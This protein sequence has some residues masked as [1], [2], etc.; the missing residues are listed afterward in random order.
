MRRML[1]GWWCGLLLVSAA[2]G[3]GSAQERALVPVGAARIDI[4]PDHPVRLCGYSNRQ[5][6]SEGVEQRLWAKALAI[7][8][9]EQPPAVLITVDSIGVPD[10]M[11]QD[12]ARRLAGDTAVKRAHLAVCSS[13]THTGPSLGGV[14]P[15]MFAGPIPPEHQQ[16][17]DRYTAEL[18]DS[19]EKV[20]RAALADRRP[21][22]LSWAEGTVGF[23]Q[24]R[25][26]L[27][28]GKWTGFGV[29]D[30]APVDHAV[31]LLRVTDAQGQLR[32]VLVNYA[33]HCTSL[34]GRFNKIN[35]DWAGYAQEFIER[36]HPGVVALVA[37]GCGADA[38]PQPRDDLSYAVQHG[39][40]LA[41]EVER[42]LAGQLRP[43]SGSVVGRIARIELP[44]DKLPTREE[45]TAR[46]AQP[47][48]LGYHA[49]VNLARLQRGEPLPTT[50]PYIV[51]TWTFGDDLAMVFLAGEV[52]VDYSLR[53][54]RELDRSRLWVNAYAN[55]VP[56]YIAS[57]RV[58]AEGGYEVDG[59]MYYY[60]RPTHF[61][62]EVEDLIIG[63]V[64]QLLPAGFQQ[65]R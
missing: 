22:R 20:A 16:N 32:A 28:D 61:A 51:Q 6:E 50:L 12:V 35:G 64:K 47:R 52:V 59:S 4:T 10:Y 58:L 23:A 19:L 2:P 17:I 7:G 33:C 25:R 57:R 39:Q 30:D 14:I 38:N 29:A 48:S 18:A 26:A 42:L 63:T 15:L 1:V 21:G 49:Q 55:D 3:V 34:G 37:I 44:F 8:G 5:T 62:P 31:P 40:T 41:Q 43:V 45:L 27:R 53:L 54:K 24:N 46:A 60:D 56:C 36:Q 13:H 65:A 11:V 9:D